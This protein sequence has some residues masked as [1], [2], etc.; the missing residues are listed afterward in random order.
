MTPAELL[1]L[2]RDRVTR[3]WCQRAIARLM[4]GEACPAESRDALSWCAVGALVAVSSPVEVHNDAFHRLRHAIGLRGDQAIGAWNDA[5]ERR[6]QDVV[7]AYDR[8]LA[9]IPQEVAA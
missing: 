5:P 9:A 6:Q 3:G 1:R 8:A 4:T 7:D 2:A